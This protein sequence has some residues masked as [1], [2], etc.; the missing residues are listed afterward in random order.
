MG[1]IRKG[2]QRVT[3][4]PKSVWKHS[5]FQLSDAHGER[6]FSTIH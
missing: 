5:D 6:D 3:I 2:L 4:D 1:S